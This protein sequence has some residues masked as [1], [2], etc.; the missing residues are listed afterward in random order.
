[1]PV[2]GLIRRTAGFDFIRVV[3]PASPL[4]WLGDALLG[5][6]G[7]RS[8]IENDAIEFLSKLL[9]FNS[10]PVQSDILNRIQDSRGHLEAEIRS[11]QG[12]RTLGT[13]VSPYNG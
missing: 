6:V 1:M 5:C 11:C 12:I 10:T 7:A 4:R 13:G 3:L 9:E 8:V 2:A